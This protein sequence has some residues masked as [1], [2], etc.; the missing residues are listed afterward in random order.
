[1]TGWG[2]RCCSAPR[3]LLW[4]TLRRLGEARLVEGEVVAAG[5][6]DVVPEV[7]NHHRTG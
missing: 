4:R 1:M 3:A 5:V 2:R 7:L 6:G